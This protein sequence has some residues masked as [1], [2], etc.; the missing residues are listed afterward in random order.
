VDEDVTLRLTLSEALV[1]FEWLATLNEEDPSGIESAEARVRWDLEAQLET[2]LPML[3]GPNYS[4]Q[5][6]QARTQVENSSP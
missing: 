5:V 4:D 3:F 6:Q 2:K 1:L